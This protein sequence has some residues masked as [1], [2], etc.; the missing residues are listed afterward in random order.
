MKTRIAFPVFLHSQGC[1][2][3]LAY[4]DNLDNLTLGKVVRCQSKGRITV[5]ELKAEN[6]S[7]SICSGEKMAMTCQYG[8]PFA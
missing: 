3:V 4:D 5:V 7:V 2:Y 8:K 1:R 6:E